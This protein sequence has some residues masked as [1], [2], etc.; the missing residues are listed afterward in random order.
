MNK[1]GTF[2]FG[3]GVILLSIVINFS[4]YRFSNLG[5]Y[6]FYMILIEPI[7]ALIILAIYGAN[8]KRILQGVISVKWGLFLVTVIFIWTYIVLVMKLGLTEVKYLF[9]SLYYPAF[10]EQV[11]F[12]MIGIETF[13]L[14][15]R[16][17]TS[18]ILSAIFYE[19]YYFVVLINALPGF[20]GIYAPLF[21]LDSFAIGLIYIGIYALS[22]SVY[23]AMALEISLIMMIVFIPPIPAAFFYSLVPS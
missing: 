12:A 22:K 13:S 9:E 14:Y 2:V 5:S 8:G 7:F 18:I 21:V 1:R 3:I 19:A 10:F 15:L 20:P 17:G 16:R 23:A 11:I 6:L 4:I